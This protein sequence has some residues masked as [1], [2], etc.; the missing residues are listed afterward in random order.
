MGDYYCF[1]SPGAMH[2]LLKDRFS[3]NTLNDFESTFNLMYSVYSLP[4]ILLPLLGGILIFKY[5]CRIMFLLFCFLVLIGQLI[6]AMGCSFM[7]IKTMIVG[8]IIF[9]FGGESLNIA[10][11]VLI[12]QWFG[13]NETAFSMGICMGVARLGSMLNELISPKMADVS[14][15]RL[16]LLSSILMY[17]QPYGLD[18]LF[19]LLAFSL[20]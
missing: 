6:F 9:G 17:V 14:L 15:N 19:A 5:G 10:Q 2:S 3:T 8:R 20:H 13:K 11:F 16:T 1:D 4:N 12:L 7:S 18:L